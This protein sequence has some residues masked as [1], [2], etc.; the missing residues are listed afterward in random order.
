MPTNLNRAHRSLTF[1]H[2]KHSFPPTIPTLAPIPLRRLR[3][4]LL[5]LPQGQFQSKCPLLLNRHNRIPRLILFHHLSMKPL[6]GSNTHQ[7]IFPGGAVHRP[8]AVLR[9]Q[10]PQLRSIQICDR[11][12]REQ[13]SREALR[14][15][16]ARVEAYRMPAVY[17]VIRQENYTDSVMRRPPVVCGVLIDEVDVITPYW[18]LLSSAQVRQVVQC[19][20]EIDEGQIS[21]CNADNG[22]WNHGVASRPFVYGMRVQAPRVPW[23]Y[24]VKVDVEGA[25]TEGRLAIGI[26]IGGPEGLRVPKRCAILLE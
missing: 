20:V 3:F 12:W 16:L 1:R 10:R 2:D 26:G 4:I 14:R 15:L 23:G 6:T 19:R 24:V 5:K 11:A 25:G 21:L 18:V 17:V 22:E 8:S 9:D 7:N 13:H